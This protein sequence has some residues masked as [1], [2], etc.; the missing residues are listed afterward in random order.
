M[1]PSIQ[2]VFYAAWVKFIKIWYALQMLFWVRR[3]KPVKKSPKIYLDNKEKAR[4]LVFARLEYFN[5]FYGFKWNRVSIKNT[6][7]RWGSCSKKGNLNFCYRVVLLPPDLVD[8]IV[9]HELCHLG[10][11]NHSSAFWAEVTK[12]IPDYP[13]KKHAL[14]NLIVYNGTI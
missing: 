11:F 8:Y 2:I 5:Q 9:V 6:R 10:Q 7:R 12:T 14:L 4:S 1:P 13:L 3:K